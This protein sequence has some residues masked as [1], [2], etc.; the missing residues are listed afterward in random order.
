MEK[1]IAAWKK[2]TPMSTLDLNSYVTVKFVT[3]VTP[4]AANNPSHL[5]RLSSLRKTDLIASSWV[6]VWVSTETHIGK[7][8][9]IIDEGGQN[10]AMTKNE[11]LIDER[12]VSPHFDFMDG[13]R[14]QAIVKYENE[15]L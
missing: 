7:I 4:S 15:E 8:R 12:E 1:E 13:Y 2:T 3:K 11:Q 10:A 9:N 14:Q 6:Q 5:N